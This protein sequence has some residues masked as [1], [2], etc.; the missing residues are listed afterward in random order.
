MSTITQNEVL[1]VLDMV[2]DGKLG[3]SIT[4]NELHV[5]YTDDAFVVSDIGTFEDIYEC[6]G[7]ILAGAK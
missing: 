1:Q 5:Q 4:I 2:R 6:S 7:V 3:D